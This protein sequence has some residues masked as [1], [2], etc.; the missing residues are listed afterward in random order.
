MTGQLIFDLPTSENYNPQDYFVSS[1]NNNAAKLIKIFPEW[2]NNGIVIFGPAKSGKTHIAYIWKSMANANLYDFKSNFD[3]NTISTN[4]NSIFDNFDFIPEK[5]EKSF[6]QI[7][8]D[9]IKNKKF[10]LILISKDNFSV[11][12]RDLKSRIEALNSA[13]LN[14]PDDKLIYAILLKFFHDNQIIVT[15]DVIN[16]ILNR[17]SRNFN[18]IHI[19]LNKL[20]DLSIKHKS[21]ISIPFLNK[22]FSF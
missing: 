11:K 22:F 3:I 6:F 9:I 1:S 7:Y 20:N 12:L 8:N 4:G 21:K 10:I 19:F 5:D 13:K 2:H 16:F 17:I 15:P 18:E 14:N